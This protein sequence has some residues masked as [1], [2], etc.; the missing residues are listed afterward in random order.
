MEARMAESVAHP[1]ETRA[2]VQAVIDVYGAAQRHPATTTC[3]ICLDIAKRGFQVPDSNV[4][5]KYTTFVN[6]T[7]YCGVHLPNVPHSTYGGSAPL[8]GQ[9]YGPSA[10][11]DGNPDV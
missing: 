9:A 11:L 10:A 8:G 6:G 2:G 1:A 3:A 4:W 7:L 5:K